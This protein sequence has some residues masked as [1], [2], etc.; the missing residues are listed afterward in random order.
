MIRTEEKRIGD[1]VY[2]ITQLPARRA[3]RLKAK[4]LRIFGAPLAQLL[5]VD[6]TDEETTKI[7]Y[8]EEGE[9]IAA[10]VKEDLVKALPMLFAQLDEKTYMEL[11]TDLTQNVK[12]DGIDL[13][14]STIDMEFAGELNTLLSVMWAVI[15]VNFGSFWKEGV[16]GKALNIQPKTHNRKPDS[17]KTSTKK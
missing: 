12:K 9:P 6:E 5:F 2:S 16:T 7:I 8:Q 1:S 15:E 3:L 10:F 14:E 4:L 11:V 13:T 17:R